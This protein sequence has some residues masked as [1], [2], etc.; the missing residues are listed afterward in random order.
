MAAI[1]KIVCKPHSHFEMVYKA[2]T[3]FGA[4][5]WAVRYIYGEQKLVDM[6]EQFKQLPPFLLSSMMPMGYLYKP[7]LHPEKIDDTVNQHNGT[8]QSKKQLKQ[9]IEQEKRKKRITIIPLTLFQ[10][11]QKNFKD[12]YQDPELLKTSLFEAGLG[13][14]EITRNAIDRISMHAREGVL[15]TEL[16]MYSQKPLVFYIKVLDSS[17]SKEWFEK[18]VELIGKNGLGKDCSVGKGIFAMSFDNLTKEEES[19]FTYTS[20][21]F[22]TLSVCAG[23]NCNPLM[24]TTF[25]RY[26]KLGG[27]Y[28]QNGIDGKLLFCK[29]PVVF[30]GE[31]SVF[32]GNGIAGSIIS[33]IHSNSSIV[34]YG[35]AFP[36]YFTS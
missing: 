26:G 14:H 31:G 8:K 35:Y 25:T 33:N 34:Q 29:K 23:S 32:N 30:Y 6:L 9:K 15:F 21:T 19:I 18:V 4:L 5:C 24:Y 20:N 28:S 7:L 11:Y 17:Y 22:C 10:K 27:A 12:I 1:Y 13:S 36:V 3:I 2:D 16:Y